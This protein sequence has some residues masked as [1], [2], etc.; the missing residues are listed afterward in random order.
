MNTY[1][2]IL[3]GINVGGHKKIKMDALRKMYTGLGF[4]KVESYIQSGNFIF[5]TRKTETQELEK[6]ISREISET[7]GFD[8][9]VLVLTKDELSDALI[10]N[11][12]RT[13]SLK[14][15]AN[16]YLTF[17]SETPDMTLLDGI[18]PVW[19]AP[20]EFLQIGKVIYNFC[21]NGY[22]KTKLTNSF[23]E[24][25]L[26]LIATSRNLRTTNE[27]MLIAEKLTE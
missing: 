5:T 11:P 4:S 27:L 22:G 26:K 10:K 19:Y 24:N 1:I 17:L 14:D 8:V 9:P 18:S 13:D 25:K 16:M 15:P 2:S 21:P 3:R 7:F 20:D 23:F 12:Y 6:M